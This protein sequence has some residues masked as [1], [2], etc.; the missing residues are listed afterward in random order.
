MNKIRVLILIVSTAILSC[1]TSTS[2]NSGYYYF[3]DLS[4]IKIESDSIYLYKL[5]DDCY[6][7]YS[8]L[9]F[10]KIDIEKFYLDKSLSNDS[11]LSV[12]INSNLRE[13]RLIQ[14]QESDWDSIRIV[15]YYNIDTSIIHAILKV[16]SAGEVRLIKNKLDTILELDQNKNLVLFK[17]FDLIN[18]DFLKF[19]K[20]SEEDGITSLR[21]QKFHNSNILFDDTGNEFS[22]NFCH[23]R[24][25]IHKMLNE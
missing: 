20:N 18:H 2:L 17:E 15:K 21:I 8:L 16:S 10:D 3:D 14:S 7:I 1:N 23:L 4:T 25:F 24:K 12:N 11:I 13:Y 19:K 6:D 22:Y 5:T 9:E